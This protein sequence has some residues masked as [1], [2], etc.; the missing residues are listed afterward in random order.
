MHIVDELIEERAT[1]LMRSPLVWRLVKRFLFPLFK[2]NEAIEMVN[3]YSSESGFNIFSDLLKTTNIRLSVAGLENLPK[4]GATV[5]VANHPAGLPDGIAIF[6]ALASVR[7]DICFM[8]NRDAIRCV[9]K[10]DEVI[11]PVEWVESKRSREKTKETL[12]A[13]RS[14]IKSQRLI[15]IFPSGRLARPS[16]SG[17]IEREWMPS[18]F[19][20]AQK[21][22][23]SIVPVH[24][25]AR[26][27]FLYYLLFFLNTELKDLTLF[28]EMLIPRKKRYE[29]TIGKPFESGSD[30]V[31]QAQTLY[32][33][34][35]KVLSR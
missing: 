22:N 24:I 17:L 30:P 19:A 31:E 4:T 13:I 10:M 1:K 21:N 15:V 2:H 6:G 5:V 35:T 7:P 23:L 27:S 25:K 3:R 8:A 18:A 9:Q 11:I 32:G 26:N 28:R 12:L 20:I 16:F 34:V 33:Y 14:A 29:V